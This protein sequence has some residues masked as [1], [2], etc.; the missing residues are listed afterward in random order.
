MKTLTN[1]TAFICLLGVLI[2][3]SCSADENLMFDQ[4]KSGIY[5]YKAAGYEFTDSLNFSFVIFPESQ[6]SETLE[7]ELHLRIMGQAA[8]EDR[9][10]NLLV[11]DSSTAVRGEHFDFPETVII[12]ANEF[13][14]FVPVTLYRT[15]DLKESVKRIYFTLEASEDFTE[16]ITDNLQHIITV[17]DQLTRPSDWNGGLTDLFYGAYSERKHEFMVQTLGTTSITM[18][19]GGSISEMMSF[20][21]QMLVALAKYEAEN[22]PMF[23][24]A[25]N[26][27]TFP[28]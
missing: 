26:Q 21:Q 4:E 18:G 1:L 6:T 24:E 5:F 15:E 23:D 10:V 13:E 27:V 9:V 16:G 25:G 12:P 3:S 22:G 14:V 7:E 19:T 2:L 11:A 28:Q 20:Q 8:A 17:T